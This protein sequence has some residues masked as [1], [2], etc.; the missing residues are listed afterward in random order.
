MPQG[1]RNLTWTCTIW[2]WTWHFLWCDWNSNFAPIDHHFPL[3]PALHQFP[4]Y[5][6]YSLALFRGLWQGGRHK[7]ELNSRAWVCYTPH[8][9]SPSRHMLGHPLAWSIQSSSLSLKAEGI[10]YA[11]PRIFIPLPQSSKPLSWYLLLQAQCLD[12]ILSKAAPHINNF[13]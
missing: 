3:G 13:Q 2:N 9:C 8:M 5:I 11:D 4:W 10:I 7:E 12:M 1:S 6:W